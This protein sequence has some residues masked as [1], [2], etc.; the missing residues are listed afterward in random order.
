MSL[1]VQNCK[2]SYMSKITLKITTSTISKES[3]NSLMIY[4]S[5]KTKGA[6]VVLMLG[7]NNT[8]KDR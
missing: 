4:I 3:M 1:E 6:I 8:R 5:V 2:I 7:K